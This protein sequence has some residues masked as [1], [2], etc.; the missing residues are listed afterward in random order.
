MGWQVAMSW[1]MASSLEAWDQP[2]NC[3]IHP[4]ISSG[5]LSLSG[6]N[7]L[8]VEDDD[9][10]GIGTGGEGRGGLSV[11]EGGEAEG[12]AAAAATSEIVVEGAF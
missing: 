3:V 4:V 12:G 8:L 6:I 5:G 9:A 7:L 10:D 1:S 11:L 2:A